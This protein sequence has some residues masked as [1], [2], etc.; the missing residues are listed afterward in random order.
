MNVAQLAEKLG[1][2]KQ[3]VWFWERGEWKPS[4]ENLKK[5]HDIFG[6]D[7]FKVFK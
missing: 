3:A 1:V 7:I 4:V 6:D 5:L 2:T